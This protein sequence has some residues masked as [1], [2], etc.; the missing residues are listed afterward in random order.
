MI[1]RGSWI[2][3]HP[4]GFRIPALICAADF[5]SRDYFTVERSETLWQS[6]YISL[7]PSLSPGS[8][9]ITINTRPVRRQHIDPSPLDPFFSFFRPIRT[10]SSG[11]PWNRSSS[12]FRDFRSQRIALAQ[13]TNYRNC[14]A[15]RKST[16]CEATTTC[17]VMKQSHT[18]FGIDP[19]WPYAHYISDPKTTVGTARPRGKT[20]FFKSDVPNSESSAVTSRKHHRTADHNQPRALDPRTRNVNLQE[21]RVKEK[22]P[23]PAISALG[24]TQKKYEKCRIS[25]SP[26]VQQANIPGIQ[27]RTSSFWTVSCARYASHIDLSPIA[28]V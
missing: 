26:H 2:F 12:R 25:E 15:R 22:E 20:I 19:N 28:S 7:S 5:L 8:F 10:E 1:N 9:H 27:I 4:Q 23:A 11:P 18:T 6:R 17:H 14:V 16:G 3:Q 21:K 13:S 24:S